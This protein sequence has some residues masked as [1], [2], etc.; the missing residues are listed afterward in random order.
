MAGSVVD[1]NAD[2]GF[3]LVTDD[4]EEGRVP[5]F[6][7]GVDGGLGPPPAAAPP[8]REVGIAGFILVLQN[9]SVRTLF[10]II[11]SQSTSKTRKNSMKLLLTG[12]RSHN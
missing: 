4:D 9:E 5:A 1:N 10:Q 8:A 12:T 7:P 11:C 2:F 3:G 6:V